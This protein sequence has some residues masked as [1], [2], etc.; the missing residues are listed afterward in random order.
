MERDVMNRM[1]AIHEAA[2]AVVAVRIGWDLVVL[3]LESDD[4]GNIDH[5]YVDVHPPKG[6]WSRNDDVLIA[7]AGHAAD[8]R[9]QRLHPGSYRYNP[10]DPYR[11]IE[12]D[13][14]W[15]FKLLGGS[16]R[17][18]SIFPRFNRQLKRA[19]SIIAEPKIWATI[20]KVAD[21]LLRKRKEKAEEV[22]RMIGRARS[23]R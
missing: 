6:R 14:T 11:S 23:T 19:D 20:L 16:G 10:A 17:A 18:D 1:M 13:L 22:V 5:G 12:L 4:H 3:E 9:L 7:L 8:L 2:H 15:A 21:I